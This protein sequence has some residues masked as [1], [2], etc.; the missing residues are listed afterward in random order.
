MVVDEF[1]LPVERLRR[2]CGSE[3]HITPTI[4]F[5]LRGWWLRSARLG[6]GKINGTIGLMD[7]VARLGC[8]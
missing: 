1:S 5:V 2:G 4:G 6:C 8:F 7:A 3:E